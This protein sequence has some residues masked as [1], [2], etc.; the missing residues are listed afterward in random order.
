MTIGKPK[1]PDNARRQ[2]F[3]DAARAAECCEEE[4]AFDEALR[5]IVKAKPAKPA[6]PL[7]KDEK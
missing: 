6:K 3:I 4:D 5:R 7:G 2:R 1:T